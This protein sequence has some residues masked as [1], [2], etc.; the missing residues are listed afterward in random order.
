MDGAQ[1]PLDGANG[2]SGLFPQRGN[3]ADQ[4]DAQ[5]LLAQHHT[6]QLRWGNASGVGRLGTCGLARFSRRAR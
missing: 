4:V 1:I 6:V 5:A 2:Q 3:Q